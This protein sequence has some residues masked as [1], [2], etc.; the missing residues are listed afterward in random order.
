MEG[1]PADTDQ[2]CSFLLSLY[3]YEEYLLVY[4]DS[5]IDICI[6]LVGCFG[7]NAQSLVVF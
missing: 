5:P 4:Y 3:I 1:T 2:Y 6:C 7:R